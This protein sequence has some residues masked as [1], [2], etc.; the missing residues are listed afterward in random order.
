[1]TDTHQLLLAID[2][3]ILLLSLGVVAVVATRHIGLS[4]IVGYLAIGLALRYA[5]HTVFKNSTTIEVL[6]EL[7][8]VFLLF[9]IGLH[10]SFTRIR[11]QAANIFGF[12]PLQV[13]LGTAVIGAGAYAFFGLPPASSLLVG[14]TLALSST[15]VVDRL[16][17]ERHQRNCPVGL[18]AI[19][20]LI[21]QDVAA[22]AI[23]VVVTSLG[24]GD[25]IALPVGLALVKAV[26]AFVAA[27][28]IA[29]F[30]VRPVFTLVVRTQNEEIFTALALL[31][32]L[33]AGWA[34]A[35]VGLSMTLG[36]FLGGVIL[37]DTPYRAVIQSEIKPFRGLLLG[38]FFVSVGLTID[39]ATIIAC[40]P[41]II[42]I[43]ALIMAGKVVSNMAASLMFRWST[44][45]S[46]QLGFLIAQASE[47][48]FVILSLPM[49]RTMLGAKASSVLIA[50]VALT[51]AATPTVAEAGR[52]FA[53]ALRAKSAKKTDPEL[54]PVEMAAPVLIFGMGT[55][56]RAVADALMEFG[57][58]YL[59][60]E[61][62]ERRLR[63]AIAD[64]YSAMFG[65]MD[66]PRLWQPMAI[67]GRKLN[68]LSDPDF[69][70]AAEI[71]PAIQEQYPDLRLLAAA[72]NADDARH[73]ADIGIEAVDDSFGDGTPLAKEV[74]TN[75]GV[76]QAAVGEWIAKC[77]EAMSEDIREAA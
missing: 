46:M 36:A 11:E 14:A 58:G 45:G 20:I 9:D 51:L 1:M 44:P 23:L 19:A 26:G 34:T 5:G 4:P 17:H 21:F 32:A 16:I 50:S 12:G 59:G 72:L 62:D 30:V 8:V 74:L 37:A 76:D 47:F 71:M 67:E 64:G 25:A 41:A 18:T 54:I 57:I 60:V 69:E 29:R 43:S 55:R 75:L 24:S 3:V 6:S 10:F 77:K 35:A 33:S 53:G 63:N 22:I 27:A 7:G 38:F 48:A 65:R 52:R 42:A 28:L 49:V 73:F 56:G 68:V 70:I 61:S 31:V 39:P 13:V 2:P 66:D 15:A 40:W